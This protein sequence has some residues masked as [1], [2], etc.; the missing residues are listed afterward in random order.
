MYEEYA[1]KQWGREKGRPVRTAL[2]PPEEVCYI[3]WR[4]SSLSSQR[5]I[6]CHHHHGTEMLSDRWTFKDQTIAEACTPNVQGWPLSHTMKHLHLIPCVFVVLTH[7]RRSQKLRLRIEV[8]TRG[9]DF[10]HANFVNH[11]EKLIG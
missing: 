11:L 7:S 5:F 4:P 6:S 3:Y 9:K 10:Y 2:I 1:L 8:M